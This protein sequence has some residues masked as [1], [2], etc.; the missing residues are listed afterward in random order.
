MVVVLCL[1]SLGTS[2]HC[3]AIWYV[4]WWH[5]WWYSVWQTLLGTLL[6][7]AW[8]LV[9]YRRCSQN[10]FTL[11]SSTDLLEL[12]IKTQRQHTSRKKSLCSITVPEWLPN[13]FLVTFGLWDI[14]ASFFGDGLKIFSVNISLIIFTTKQSEPTWQTGTFFFTQFST[15]TFLQV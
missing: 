12:N 2:W 1:L 11:H 13:L 6:Q 4:W 3:S 9:S 14:F 5:S 15:G 7:W 8:Y 10:S